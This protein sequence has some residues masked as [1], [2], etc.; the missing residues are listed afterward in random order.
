MIT[1]ADELHFDRVCRD[2]LLADRDRD[3]I[4]TLK[5][6]KLHTMLKFFVCED[7]SC[8][9]IRL[10][11]HMQSE[12]PG[13]PGA[14]EL[15][16]L[17]GA[18]E[19]P[20]SP[21][22]PESSR[23]DGDGRARGFV[24]DVLCGDD[25]F[26][27]Q[28]GSLYPLRDKIEFYLGHTGYNVTVI[29]PLVAKKRVTYL[30]PVDAHVVR[31]VSSPK[32]EHAVDMVAEL[33][34]LLPFLGN[35]RLRIRAMMLEMEEFRI[36]NKRGRHGAIRYEKIPTRLLDIFDFNTPDDYLPHFPAMLPSEFTA[37]E[38]GRAAGL[39]GVDVYSALKVFVAMGLAAPYGERGRAATYTVTN[40]AE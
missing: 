20:A 11:L 39:R 9:E 13:L 40:P 21:A 12:S 16:A 10:G 32:H 25:I 1:V 37:S 28:T 3:G 24:A 17:P 27:I 29:H 7:K 26:E 36:Q 33:Y 30:S 31:R 19:S 18:P 35:P 5:E 38:F 15:P 2:V 22:S 34:S 4:G 14:P 6:K 8:H 23:P